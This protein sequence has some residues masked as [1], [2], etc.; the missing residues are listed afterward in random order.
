MFNIAIGYG[1][2]SMTWKDG[3]LCLEWQMFDEGGNVTN[4]KKKLDQEQNRNRSEF[5]TLSEGK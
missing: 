5:E 2:P 1:R 3:D 4:P